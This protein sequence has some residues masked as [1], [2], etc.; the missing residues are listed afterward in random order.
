MSYENKLNFPRDIM[1]NVYPS[2]DGINQIYVE[3]HIRFKF[4]SRKPKENY[5]ALITA[6]TDKNDKTTLF[7]YNTEN[8]QEVDDI[9]Y[10]FIEKQ[11]IPE[12]H[13]WIKF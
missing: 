8:I 1:V 7:L 12:L 13:R 3:H 6:Q 4:L 2:I 10:Y 9:L 5:F 11:Q